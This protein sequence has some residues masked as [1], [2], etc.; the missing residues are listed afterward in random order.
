M[1][2]AIIFD[3][4]GVIVDYKEEQYYDYLSKKYNINRALIPKVFDPLIEEMECG[5]M[6]LSEMLQIVSKKLG[7][8]KEEIEWTS[9]FKRIGKR[10]EKMLKLLKILSKNYKVYLL[11]NISKSRYTEALKD[12]INNETNLFDKR[13]A[14][15]YIGFRKPDKRIYRYVLKNINVRADEAVFI[16]DREENIKG[17]ESVGINGVLCTN[18]NN[19]VSS[20]KKFGIKVQ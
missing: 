20:I 4:G 18:Y 15:C 5:K 6:K 17:A 13:F 8:T 1:I 11:S 14:S 7:I 2:K 19:V 10:N 12:F 9:A 3:M 16:D